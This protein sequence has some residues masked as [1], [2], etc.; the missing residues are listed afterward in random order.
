MKYD[1]VWHKNLYSIEE[2][3]SL[4]KLCTE[5]VNLLVGDKK[6]EGV[7]KTANVGSF[8]LG[9]LRSE[10]NKFNQTI[11][12][13][14]R[15]NFGL[16]VFET[17]DQEYLNLNVYNWV[18]KGEYSWHS[19]KVLNEPYDI[20]LT[21]ILNLGTEEFTG[22]N[23]ELFLNEP[24]VVKEINEPGT[25]LVFP[26]YIQHRVTPVTSGE[27]VTISRWVNGPTYKSNVQTSSNRRS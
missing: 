14:N 3:Q 11:I 5:H 16:D 27:R 25:L 18:N 15:N 2:C 9:P 17:C 24:I 6:A 1:Y 22:G 10:L 19:D 7:K 20:K 8:A 21:A 12:S 23:F 4:K 13:I 26:S